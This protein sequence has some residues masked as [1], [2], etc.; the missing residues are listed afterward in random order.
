MGAQSVSGDRSRSASNRAPAPVT[1]R[2]IGFN[3]LPCLR[4]PESVRSIS[5]LARVAAI[6][7]NSVDAVS[8]RLRAL[9]DGGRSPDLC[10]FHIGDRAAGRRQFRPRELSEAVKRADAEEVGQPV[11]RRRAVERTPPEAA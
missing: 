3:R 6:D 10:A 7:M 9:Q 4:S 2:S 8:S 5:R 1:V 11:L